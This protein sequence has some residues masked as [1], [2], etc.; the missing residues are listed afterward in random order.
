MISLS[1]L[2]EAKGQAIPAIPPV[3]PLH[4]TVHTLAGAY[5]AGEPV[6]CRNCGQ[7]LGTALQAGNLPPGI[8]YVQEGFLQPARPKGVRFAVPCYSQPSH[9]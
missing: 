3:D 1:Q 9:N 4:A 7:Q 2:L 6:H 5:Q 8:V